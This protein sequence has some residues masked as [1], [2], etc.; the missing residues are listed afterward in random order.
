MGIENAVINY[1]CPDCGQRFPVT[2]RMLFHGLINCPGC[3]P[4]NTNINL[5]DLLSELNQL[6][7]DLMKLRRNMDSSHR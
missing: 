1:R 5:N 7:R 6:S 2:M 4:E 3:R